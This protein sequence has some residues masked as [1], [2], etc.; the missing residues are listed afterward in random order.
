MVGFEEFFCSAVG[1]NP[2]EYQKE[3]A[4]R[5]APPT[6]LS[7][8]TGCGK[9]AAAVLSWLWRRR[10]P[11]TRE[12]TPRRLVYCLPMR[13]LVDQV[14]ESVDKW[15]GNLRRLGNLGVDDKV[16]VAVL[17]G[18][19]V[20]RDWVL[21]PESD[22]ILIGTQDMLLSRAMNRGYGLPS[23]AW[24]IDFGMLNN[25]SFWVID[26][27]QLMANGLPTSVQL[28]SLRKTMGTYGKCETMWMSATIKE[29]DLATPDFEKGIHDTFSPVD[30]NPKITMAKKSLQMLDGVLSKGICYADADA[31]KIFGCHQE[32]T[33]T[34]VIVN[35]VGRAQS[36]YKS[37]K[38]IVGSKTQV[39]LVHSR[40]RPAERLSINRALVEGAESHD[41]DVIIVS[42]QAI[43]AGIDISSYTLVSELAPVTSMVQRFGRC[44]RRGEYK[45]GARV[46]WIDAD[47]SDGAPYEIT[48]LEESR[49]WLKGL[50]SA[51]STDLVYTKAARLH[52]AVLR[53]S[54]LYALFDTAP[55]LSGTYLD[56]SRFVRHSDA[57]TDVLVYWRDVPKGRGPDKEMAHH[58]RDEVCSVPIGD[59]KK[60]VGAHKS[61]AWHYDYAGEDY[62]D[63]PWVGVSASD[64]RPGQVLLVDT[65]SGGYSNELG[66]YPGEP[67][68]TEASRQQKITHTATRP[69]IELDTH[70]RNVRSTAEAI[71]DGISLLDA[72]A[73]DSVL[74]AALFHDVGKSHHVFQNTLVGG[75]ADSSGKLWA[76][77][78]GRG[79]THERRNFRHE[80]ASALAYLEHHG[81]EPGSSLTAYLIAAHHGKVRMSLRSSVS[82]AADTPDGR[83]LLGFSTNPSMPDE[84]PCS[85]LGDGSEFPRTKIRMDAATIGRRKDGRPSW[86]SMTTSLRDE[87]ELGPFRLAYLESLV[88]A[89]DVR[90]SK[91]EEEAG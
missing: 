75:I 7:V 25:D 27:V 4:A 88:R 37:I 46:F 76:K 74:K 8:P 1:K 71:V 78:P 59:F 50:P 58:A 53:K 41:R 66:W 47:V 32:G 62:S 40:F 77:S 55:D 18:G 21:E 30:P 87:G 83:Y 52:D 86:L 72:R 84:I 31:K 44:N 80:A 91:G 90:A 2:Y 39:I 23:S 3:L 68:T 22:A 5:N 57:E 12:D 54:D 64:V 11:D 29:E 67:K 45:N 36:L 56:V 79:R 51:S 17:M 48:A 73:K 15:L 10:M 6:I 14:K 13:T 19:S 16:A 28:D 60:F 70:S 38:K 35:R 69:W 89:A 20:D 24:P 82:R 81:S 9:T 43:E 49:K 61:G 26:E 42:T 63:N 33:P 34:L 65:D 85:K